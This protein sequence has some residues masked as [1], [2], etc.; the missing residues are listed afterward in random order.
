MYCDNCDALFKFQFRTNHDGPEREY[1]Y[2]S[3]LS[4]TSP[5]DEDAWL[6]PRPLSLFLREK[7]PVPIL[8]ESVWAPE[9]GGEKCR[10]RP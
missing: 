9:E 3:T 5:L 10:P 7:D 4:L 1:R 2:S 6:T 8:Q